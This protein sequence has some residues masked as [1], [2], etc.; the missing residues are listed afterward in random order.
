M[1]ES[2]VAR[3]S[4]SVCCKQ[5]NLHEILKARWIERSIG[6]FFMNGVILMAYKTQIFS[7]VERNGIGLE[8]LSEGG[9]VLASAW[10]T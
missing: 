1:G 10:T 4:K 2:V 3:S 9:D 8:L 6:F 7:D 5:S